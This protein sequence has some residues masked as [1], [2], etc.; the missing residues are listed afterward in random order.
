MFKYI[1]TKIIYVNVPPWCY[2]KTFKVFD[3]FDE[4]KDYVQKEYDNFRE[5]TVSP[6]KPFFHLYRKFTSHRRP[7]SCTGEVYQFYYIFNKLDDEDEA[8][9]IR[10]YEISICSDNSELQI[11]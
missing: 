4:A 5:I 9:L 6:A 3:N 7:F 11:L 10:E 2:S 1:V 8:R